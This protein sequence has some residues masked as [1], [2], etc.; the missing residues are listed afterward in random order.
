MFGSHEF[1]TFIGKFS[2]STFSFNE[3][4]YETLHQLHSIIRQNLYLTR[5]VYLNSDDIAKKKRETAV[6][7]G[8]FSYI[9]RTEQQSP[10]PLQ[11]DKAQDPRIVKRLKRRPETPKDDDEDIQVIT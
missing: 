1:A 11:L 8:L 3:E 10:N 6:R 9:P 4:S 5:K 7:R 2:P